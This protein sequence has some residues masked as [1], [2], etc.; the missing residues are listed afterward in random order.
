MTTALLMHGQYE[1]VADFYDEILKRGLSITDPA[2]YEVFYNAIEL[3]RCNLLCDRV[4]KAESLVGQFLEIHG[5][6]NEDGSL[7]LYGAMLHRFFAVIHLKI[8]RVQK[9]VE[10]NRQVITGLGE[11]VNLFK[12]HCLVEMV[13]LLGALSQDEVVA[14]LK[15][16]LTQF[17]ERE[18][19]RD[20]A[21]YLE[22]LKVVEKWKAGSISISRTSVALE[23]FIEWV[24]QRDMF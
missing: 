23:E 8:G 24:L 7:N 20:L 1:V 9:A 10:E 6:E 17:R 5:R 3:T 12:H 21:G 19:S 15:E 11:G 22:A 4:A 18:G 2:N 14:A 16:L 13:M